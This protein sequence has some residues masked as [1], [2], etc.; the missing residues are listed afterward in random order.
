MPKTTAG[1]A[2]RVVLLGLD[3]GTFRLIKPWAEEGHLPN[4]ARLFSEAAWGKLAST[5]PP[6]TPP[7]WAACLTGKNPGKHGIFDFR[8]S[9]LKFP[10]RPLINLSSMQGRK[11]WHIFNSAGKKVAIINVPI[12]YPPE[13]VDGLM[14]SGMMTPSDD[15]PYAYPAEL[16]DEIHRA[17][18]DYV[19][20]I[21]IPQYDVELEADALRFMDDIDHSFR[22]RQKAMFYLLE[23]KEW[24]FFMIVFI[25]MDRIQHLFWKYIDP[26]WETHYHS[27]MA[28]K[29][30]PR[31]IAS[32]QMAD[33]MLGELRA[34]L[35]DTPLLIM[36]DHGF[37]PTREWFNVN[38]WLRQQGYLK[39]KSGILLK[40]QIFSFFMNLND[41]RLVKSVVPKRIQSAV[42]GKI[43]GTRSTFKSDL[44]AA[45]DYTGTKAFFASIPSQGIFINIK[46]DGAGIVKPGAEYDELRA[47]IREKL[48]EL[49]HSRTGQ[50]AIDKVYYREEI[51]RG[52]QTRF[53]ADLLFVAQNYA[54]LGRQ[55][56]GLSAVFQSS[57]HTPNGF[58]R[59][60]G[61][62][63]AVGPQFKAG[64][65]LQGADIADIA[66]TVLH[67][68]GQPV[69]DDMDGV[70]LTDAFQSEF[71]AARPVQKI[72]A[73]S[74]A[75]SQRQDF[76]SQETDEIAKRLRSLGYLE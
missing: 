21:D 10:D 58:H 6:T 3:G 28:K 18:G 68:C 64:Y 61:I 31:I 36:S 7:A 66:P 37:G 76:T 26:Q 51:Y 47:Q 14:I 30:R 12:T 23:N 75:D 22:Q 56:L 53:A 1:V 4:F 15:S 62:F 25:I 59:P 38:T 73:A 5:I 19:V 35:G 69:P 11:L 9:P 33:E 60:D 44:E 24:T 55:L 45:L 65:E 74:F 39:V 42:R 34:K 29:L 8:E 13:P 49:R 54:C 70:V 72:S 63:Y 48:L 27:P 20:N 41:S 50:R 67:L 2:D 17:V 40:K 46:R 16:K 52:D 43:R 57:A 32:F 71:M